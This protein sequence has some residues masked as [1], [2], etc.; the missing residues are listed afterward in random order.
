MNEARM[1]VSDRRVS[2]KSSERM[3]ALGDG[4]T[5]GCESKYS[6][7]NSSKRQVVGM[8]GSSND[9]VQRGSYN[10]NVSG[11]KRPLRDIKKNKTV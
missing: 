6:R 7:K 9:M 4:G 10:S 8:T 2:V 1:Q 11:N 3:V 5:G